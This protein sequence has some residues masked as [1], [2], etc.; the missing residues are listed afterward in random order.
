MA[1]CGKKHLENVEQ[2]NCVCNVTG[3]GNIV[4]VGCQGASINSVAWA[5][6]SNWAP[7]VMPILSGLFC[8][9]VCE[10]GLIR[11]GPFCEIVNPKKFC[12]FL[13]FIS[14]YPRL[15]GTSLLPHLT[16]KCCV[17][18]N[19]LKYKCTVKINSPWDS[20][21]GPSLGKHQ[22]IDE[23]WTDSHKCT[24]QLTAA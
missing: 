14:F 11:S 9:V 13:I 5:M 24:L 18:D 2:N 21:S 7:H 15:G 12:N 8:K 6:E 17:L 1:K 16:W 19:C 3:F 20:Q 22:W 23:R 10:F 4:T